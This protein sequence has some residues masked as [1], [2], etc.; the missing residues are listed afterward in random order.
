MD[1]NGP[2]SI[3]QVFQSFRVEDECSAEQTAIAIETNIHIAM[4]EKIF[5]IFEEDFFLSFLFIM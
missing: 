3:K 1:L 5:S 4:L 2:I